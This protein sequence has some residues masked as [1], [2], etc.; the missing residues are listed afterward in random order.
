M[1]NRTVISCGLV[2][3]ALCVAI[4]VWSTV[5]IVNH[6]SAY[7]LQLS[8]LSAP[9]AGAQPMSETDWRLRA[10]AVEK[11]YGIGQPIDCAGAEEM[12]QRGFAEGD[13][14]AGGHLYTLLATAP[15]Y[16]SR[17]A[18]A[19]AIWPQV[20][21][22]LWD[23]AENGNMEAQCIIALAFI[24]IEDDAGWSEYISNVASNAN[25]TY[26]PSL[27]LK[28]NLLEWGMHVERDLLEAEMWYRMAHDKGCVYGASGL[29]RLYSTPEF[30]GF[31]IERA[32]QLFAESAAQG[33]INSYERLGTI[34]E[35]GIGLEA[36]P[37]LAR[38]FYR[39]AVEAGSM[40][41]GLPLARLL[42]SEGGES[43]MAEA[44]ELLDSL[45]Q[46][47]SVMD[48]AVR[49]EDEDAQL[50]DELRQQHD[51]A[52]RAGVE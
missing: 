34:Y 33:D 41:A 45:A 6:F 5:L 38:D 10:A 30:G 19:E 27:L 49:T 47:Y 17:R 48:D 26:V 9:G 52:G 15:N 43:G 20:E 24:G 29:A 22:A 14:L 42:I 23:F 51:E 2:A 40:H 37:G 12:L 39:Q 28:G 1:N 32:L 4:L 46:E 11:R 21:P 25:S 7:P 36:D 35:E 50:L 13:M 3:L 31:D 8:F 16:R 18:E 44:G